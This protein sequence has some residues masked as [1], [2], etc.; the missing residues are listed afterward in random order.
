MLRLTLIILAVIALIW[1]IAPMVHDEGTEMGFAVGGP[2]PNVYKTTFLFGWPLTWITW[3]RSWNEAA[4][5]DKSSVASFSVV[6]FV[7]HVSAIAVPLL[8]Y[9][10]SRRPGR[11]Q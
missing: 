11:D 5:Y 6:N 4:G 9:R 7:I 3:E 2:D 8:L 10:R 1:M